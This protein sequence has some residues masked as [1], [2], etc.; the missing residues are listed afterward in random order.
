MKV[1][2]LKDNVIGNTKCWNEVDVANKYKDSEILIIIEFLDFDL[3]LKFTD[4][5]WILIFELWVSFLW[6]TLVLSRLRLL[7]RLSSRT[8]LSGRSL[9]KLNWLYKFIYKAFE[10]G[11]LFK[12]LKLDLLLKLK[13]LLLIQ[14][15][16]KLSR[17][18]W[19]LN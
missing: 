5:F 18:F 12:K 17:N 1:W 4:L 9:S 8:K 7:D 16:T 14:W 3:E 6:L 19:F 13:L 15:P 10:F 2:L 11:L